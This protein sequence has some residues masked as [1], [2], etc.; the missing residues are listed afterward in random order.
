MSTSGKCLG[1]GSSDA[2]DGDRWDGQF[3][4]HCSD[5]WPEPIRNAVENGAAIEN[6]Q[7]PTGVRYWLRTNGAEPFEFTTAYIEGDW[8]RAIGSRGATWFA[9]SAMISAGRLTGY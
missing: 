5:V 3:C 6:G 9:R 7:Q 8:V 1:C 2:W 4:L